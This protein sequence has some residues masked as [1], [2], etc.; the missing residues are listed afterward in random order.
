MRRPSGRAAWRPI[1]SGRFR[2]PPGVEGE[3]GPGT[4]EAVAFIERD[5]RERHVRVPVRGVALP[6]AAA[7]RR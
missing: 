7:Q 2:V 4:L 6:S 3:A 1:A 5:E